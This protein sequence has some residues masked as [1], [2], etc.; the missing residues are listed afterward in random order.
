MHCVD[1]GESFP[2]HIYLQK[3]ASI[4]LR[5][6]PLKFAASVPSDLPRTGQPSYG[7]A[8]SVIGQPGAVIG[9]P[10][11]GRIANFAWGAK[12]PPTRAAAVVQFRG[13]VLGC[14]EAKFC[15]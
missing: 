9:Q 14:I 4:Q 6:S 2:T 10:V 11:R 8:G 15:K 13:L 7:G 5:T 12:S 3:F 1:L